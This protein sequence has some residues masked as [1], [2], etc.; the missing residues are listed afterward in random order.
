MPN[1]ELLFD[2]IALCRASVHY[3]KILLHTV[4]SITLVGNTERYP[5]THRS[6]AWDLHQA[7]DNVQRKKTKRSEF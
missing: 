1:L 3:P 7:L 5:K 2:D 4:E 6:R